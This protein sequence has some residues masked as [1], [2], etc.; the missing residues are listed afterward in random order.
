MHG[1]VDARQCIL[2]AMQNFGP[3]GFGDYVRSI[4]ALGRYL[5]FMM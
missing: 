1:N 5:L 2:S 3:S 4:G